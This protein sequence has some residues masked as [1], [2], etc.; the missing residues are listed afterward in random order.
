[1]LLIDFGEDRSRTP[2]LY[3]FEFIKKIQQKVKANNIDTDIKQIVLNKAW[4]RDQREKIEQT[5]IRTD[6]RL[7]FL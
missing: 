7:Q 2:N 4:I 5:R 3:L 1:M 6:E